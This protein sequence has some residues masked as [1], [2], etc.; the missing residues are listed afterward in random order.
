VSLDIVERRGPA[1]HRRANSLADDVR[2][3]DPY[4]VGL[5]KK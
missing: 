1:R 2:V 5:L 3:A 4:N